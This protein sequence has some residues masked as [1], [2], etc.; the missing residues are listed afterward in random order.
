MISATL[1]WAL[2]RKSSKPTGNKVT[3]PAF[4]IN[5]ILILHVNNSMQDFE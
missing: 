1:K 4:K 3:Y 2:Y 5:W